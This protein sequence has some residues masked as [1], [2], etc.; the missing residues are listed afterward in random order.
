MAPLREGAAKS[1]CKRGSAPIFDGFYITGES[2]DSP[3][4]RLGGARRLRSI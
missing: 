1:P 3:E 2:S 4:I